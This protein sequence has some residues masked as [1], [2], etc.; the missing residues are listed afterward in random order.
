MP[1]VK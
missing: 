1:S